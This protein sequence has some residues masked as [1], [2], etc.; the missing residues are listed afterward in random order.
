[1]NITETSAYQCGECKKVYLDRRMAEQCCLHKYCED[2]GCELPSRWYKFVCK[3]CDLKR[4]YDKAEKLTPDQWD[5]WVQRDGYGYNDGFFESVD[6]LLEYCKDTGSEPP[7]WVFCCKGIRHQ[8][9][10]D[11]ILDNM[12]DDA[13]DDAPDQIVDEDSLRDFIKAWNAKQIVSTYYPDYT[14]VVVLKTGRI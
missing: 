12:L 10:A 4:L 6:D 11:Q 9:D 8:L 3:S 13:Y 2:C 5:D 7:D 1:M 14:K